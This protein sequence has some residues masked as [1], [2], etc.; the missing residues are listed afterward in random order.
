M[1][2]EN[3]MILLASGKVKLSTLPVR[4]T[5]KVG[6]MSDR[7]VGETK[8]TTADIHDLKFKSSYLQEPDLLFGDQNEEKDPR[9][10]LKYHGPY[11]PYKYPS[12]SIPLP[13]HVKLGIV[14]SG[15]SIS[16]SKEVLDLLKIPISSKSINKWLYQ[17]TPH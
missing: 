3:G 8:L 10:G 4:S 14:G 15:H 6:I 12:E 16:K 2:G 7:P 13:S 9:L 17:F 1:S 5:T 11:R